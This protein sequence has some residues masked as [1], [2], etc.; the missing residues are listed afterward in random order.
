YVPVAGWSD[1]ASFG[2]QGDSIDLQA[3]EVWDLSAEMAVDGEPTL[4][5]LRN[6]AGREVSSK[7]YTEQNGVF[8]FHRAGHYV[9]TLRNPRLRN[10]IDGEVADTVSF[11]WYIKVEGD[12]PEVVMYTVTLAGSP[13]AGGVL[14]G[15]GQYEEESAV[16]VTAE[17]QADYYFVNWTDAT[18]Q[19]VSD[20]RSY[21]FMITSNVALTANF[22]ARPVDVET[23]TVSVSSNNA[24]W[25]R[26]SIT[27]D[28]T[29]EKGSEV[30]ISAKAN[31][32]YRFVNWTQGG[33]EFSTEGTHTFRVTEDVAL[34]ANFEARPAGVETFTVSVSS[35]NTAWG[36][37]S[38]TG[39]GTYEKGSEVT[40]IAKANTGYRFVN[41][42]QGGVVFS[43]ATH[44]FTVTE[45]V[46]LTANFEAR[47]VD[48]ET[49]TVSVSSNN[50]AW[51]RV[52][53]T[54]DGTYE[55]GSEVTITAT[56]NAGYRF[57]NWTQDG[58]SFS[59]KATY[60]FTVT[61]D[62]MLTAN[63]KEKVANEPMEEPQ[64]Y[65]YAKDRTIYLS[66]PMGYVTVCDMSGSCIYKGNATAIPVKTGGVYVVSAS[67]H[68]F[69]ILVR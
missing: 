31:T 14:T 7:V 44:T 36:R 39:D 54:G 10:L 33:L 6:Q 58:L 21:T 51:G 24:A 22:E 26:V 69:K 49:F 50:A 48:V 2:P 65:V 18:G 13:E 20:A 66:V 27:G 43:T 47:P 16:T 42:T 62:L 40:V 38:I 17:P 12:V 59:A 61:E 4:W 56:A 25:G 3:E 68:H 1:T 63:F 32:G 11:T 57:V 8:T 9:L 28:G 67:G 34:M 19:V 29:Y 15:G 30:T 23:F 41:W 60:T 46:M 37:V 5:Q 53:I 64:G 52:T 35:N 55:K 45:D